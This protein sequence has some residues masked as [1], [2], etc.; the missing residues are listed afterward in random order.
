MLILML[1]LK[2]MLDE[3]TSVVDTQGHY[4]SGWWCGR[5]GCGGVHDTASQDGCCGI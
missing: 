1:I 4:M 2:G 3:V 5:C